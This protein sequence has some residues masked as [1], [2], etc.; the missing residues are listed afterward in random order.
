MASDR[1]KDY[2]E[3]T[4]SGK[5]LLVKYPLDKIG[6]WKILGEDPDPGL[7]GSHYQPELAIV[8]GDL[9]T[10]IRYGV[11]LPGFWN[12]GAGGNF[13]FVGEDIASIDASTLQDREELK[14][15]LKLL[16]ARRDE[17]KAK[18]GIK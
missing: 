4:H 13:V 12:W 3:R 11:A 1:Y 18:L 2:T 6:I 14:A 17:I 9:D 10:V 15:E 5:Q 8:R 16:E 7:H